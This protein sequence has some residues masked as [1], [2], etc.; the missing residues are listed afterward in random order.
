MFEKLVTTSRPT[1]RRRHP[2]PAEDEIP[3]RPGVP[4]EV[5]TVSS[6]DGTRL[7]VEIRGRT[8][9]P[10]IVLS[11]GVLCAL[12]FWRHQIHQLSTEFRVVAYDQRG[13]GRSEVAPRGQYTLGHLAD[14]LHA[15]LAATVSPEQPAVIAGHSMGGIAV[16]AWAR[17]YPTE[18]PTRA[19][20]VALVNTTPGQV[21]DHVAFLRGPDRLL[22]LRRRL[23]QAAAP[24][25]GLPLPRRLPGRRHLLRRVAVG[26]QAPAGVV[27]EVDAMVSAT[28]ARAR[29]SCGTTLVNL[30]ETLDPAAISVPA[31][32]IAGRT[33]RITPPERSRLLASKLPR[34]LGLRELD[35]GHC[36][37]LERPEEVR[38]ALRELAQLPP[39]QS[40]AHQATT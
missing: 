4:V 16:L 5:R 1:G 33:D 36:S 37:P 19:S 9:A 24:L 22:P 8:D 38:T 6:S 11:H 13:H 30:V 34:L 15:V 2:K 27:R 7:H 17:R 10:T 26:P 31:L 35:C 20:A 29:G 14:D 39:Q 32:V 25:A 23:A 21:L 28:A 18:V 12:R 3:T 40:A